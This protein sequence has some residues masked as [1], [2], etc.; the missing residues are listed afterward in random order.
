MKISEKKVVVSIAVSPE[1]R[2]KLKKIP[3][4]TNW[5]ESLILSNIGMEP[6]PTCHSGTPGKRLSGMVRARPLAG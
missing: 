1:V 4:Y 3:R 5:I 2:R 6:C